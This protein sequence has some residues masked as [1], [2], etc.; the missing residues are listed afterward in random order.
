MAHE[1]ID[2]E[3]WKI[4]QPLLLPVR[5]RR[6]PH[7]GRKRLGERRA[8][9]GILF[10]LQPGDLVVTDNLDSHKVTGVAH[11]IEAV[12]TR[13]RYLPQYSP[14]YKPIEQVFA[15]FKTLLRKTAAHT[16]DNLWSTCGSL[17]DQFTAT[18]CKRYICHAGYGQSE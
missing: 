3:L 15:K 17:L 8:L 18:E 9:T 10:V 1:Q 16:M 2:N 4:V 7:P 12:G 14:D 5:R 6:K 11:T 13:L